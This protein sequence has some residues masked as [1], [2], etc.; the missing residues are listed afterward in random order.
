M[1]IKTEFFKYDD[2]EH[3][4]QITTDDSTHEVIKRLHR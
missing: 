2:L 3:T 4:L 1:G